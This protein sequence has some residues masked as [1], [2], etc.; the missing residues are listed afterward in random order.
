MCVA[1]VDKILC[2][3][4]GQDGCGGFVADIAGSWSAR[5]LGSIDMELARLS[6]I[7][8]TDTHALVIQVCERHETRL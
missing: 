1:R 4:C 3:Q 8:Q 6:E 5:G 7:Y 2:L